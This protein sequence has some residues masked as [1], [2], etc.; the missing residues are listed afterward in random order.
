ML[1]ERKQVLS[2]ANIADGARDIASKRNLMPISTFR[3]NLSSVSMTFLSFMLM[4]SLERL[5]IAFV[6]DD[7]DKC[8]LSGDN[9]C[10]GETNCCCD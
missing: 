10:H 8:N 9:S 4:L 2:V 7:F 3:Y 1:I 5:K 6:N